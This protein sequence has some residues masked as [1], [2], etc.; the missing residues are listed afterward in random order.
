MVDR[1]R[2][3]QAGRSADVE[4][5]E[6]HRDMETRE[7]WGWYIF[8]RDRASRQMCWVIEPGTRRVRTGDNAVRINADAHSDT[9]QTGKLSFICYILYWPHSAPTGHFHLPKFT[10][11][12]PR[13]NKGGGKWTQTWLGRKTWNVFSKWFVH[14]PKIRDWL[15]PINRLSKSLVYWHHW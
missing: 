12:W 14:N 4:Y 3:W 15:K 1:S 2:Q 8:T 5:L 9:L 10:Y 11:L 7:S 6:V 13:G